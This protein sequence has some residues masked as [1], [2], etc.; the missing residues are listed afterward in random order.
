MPE[1]ELSRNGDSA[2]GS[3][4]YNPTLYIRTSQISEQIYPS[5]GI[6]MDRKVM[7]KRVMGCLL[8]LFVEVCVAAGGRNKV[9]SGKP[10][11]S[12]GS[13][14]ISSSSNNSALTIGL[15]TFLV[16]V[17]GYLFFSSSNTN[18][19][20]GSNNRQQGATNRPSGTGIR[21][22]GSTAKTGIGK[23]DIHLSETNLKNMSILGLPEQNGV[24]SISVNKVRVFVLRIGNQTVS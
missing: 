23:F 17:I 22:E 2:S 3:I 21:S 7:V 4:E 5:L 8:L 1:I 11:S 16:L 19:I 18:N 13:N 9:G 24:I 20:M 12:A 10:S 6:N 14:N 15:A